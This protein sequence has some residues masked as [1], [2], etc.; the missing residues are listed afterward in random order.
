MTAD[1][2][3][4]DRGTSD[5]GRV[6]R[7]GAARGGSAR[8]PRA[9]SKRTRGQHRDPRRTTLPRWG[10]NRG[11]TADGAAHRTAA[12][13]PAADTGAA[14]RAGRTPTAGDTGGRSGSGSS[15]PAPGQVVLLSVALPS[16][17]VPGSFSPA[18]ATARTDTALRPALVPALPRALPPAL[19]PALPRALPPGPRPALA[20]PVPQPPAVLAPAAP[21]P[22]PAVP[23]TTAPEADRPA[24]CL[25][26]AARG[27][28]AVFGRAGAHWAARHTG[29]DFP[30]PAGTAVHAVTDGALSTGW[31][32]AYGYLAIVR[33]A[34]GTETWYAHLS[35]CRLR[36]GPVR[37]GDVIAASGATGNATG[38]H[39]HLEVRPRGGEPVDPLPW[40]LARGLDPR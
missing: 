40:L 5:P 22:A 30:V 8:L 7:T 4:A 32:P 6:D 34:D 13:G 20:P 27:L 14:E 33:A 38:P 24:F 16:A 10:L 37:A 39:L 1:S 9:R 29:I 35:G 28:G 36:N 3:G 25:P 2:S 11:A 31:T 12:V 17:T 19:P 21:A 15:G 26:V 18:A 23:D